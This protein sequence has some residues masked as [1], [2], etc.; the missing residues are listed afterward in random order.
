M[1]GFTYGHGFVDYR[2]VHSRLRSPTILTGRRVPI[3]S[4]SA[5]RPDPARRPSPL[6]TGAFGALSLVQFLQQRLVADLEQAGGRR[7][8]ATDTLERVSKR[9]CS[10]VRAARRPT[11]RRPRS[12]ADAGFCLP[13]T[14]SRPQP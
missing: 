1:R 10:A 7:A 9:C 2:D 14:L 12:S 6:P 11:S 3:K 5:R 8:V 4:L 13:F